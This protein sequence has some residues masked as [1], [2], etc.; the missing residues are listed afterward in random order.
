MGSHVLID[1][2]NDVLI[3]LGVA[4]IFALV[5]ILLFINGTII[6]PRGIQKTFKDNDEE[7]DNDGQ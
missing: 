6:S 3:G 7:E 2:S 4:L 1:V 5:I